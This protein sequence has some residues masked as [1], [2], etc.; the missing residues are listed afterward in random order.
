MAINHNRKTMQQR[1]VEGNSGRDS[2]EELLDEEQQ[3]EEQLLTD[4]Q[5]LFLDGLER[6]GER[7]PR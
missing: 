5:W 2:V 6:V 1:V 7:L 4:N 3:D